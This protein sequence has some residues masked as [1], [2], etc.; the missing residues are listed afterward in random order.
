MASP[1]EVAELLLGLVR[2]RL[3]TLGQ[4]RLLCI[5]GPAAAGKTTLAAAVAELE[6]DTAVVH[7]DDL[8]DGWRGL[9]TVAEAVDAL[10]RPLARGEVGSYRR[11]D[12]D[13]YRFAETV[14]VRPQS[15]LVLEGCGAGSRAYAD[16]ATVIAWVSAPTDL[17]VTRGVERDGERLRD[18]QAQWLADEALLFAAEDT[19]A[20]A[21]VEV[22][23][24]GHRPPT[25]RTGP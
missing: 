18:R 24:T 9:S 19:R 2:S 5:D 20:R 25:L 17:R 12:W 7:V 21:D 4:S 1:S 3:P 13:L 22:D 8:L 6:P 16:L 11:F 15:L 23:G 14:H 10:L